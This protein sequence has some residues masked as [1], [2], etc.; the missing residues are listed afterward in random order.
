MSEII[1]VKRSFKKTSWN[2]VDWETMQYFELELDQKLMTWCELHYNRP[3]Y[4]RTWWSTHNSIVINEKIYVH[5]KLC[6]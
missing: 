6:E 2:G 4:T 1:P 5:W 3:K